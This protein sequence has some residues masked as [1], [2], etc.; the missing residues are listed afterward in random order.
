MIKLRGIEIELE[1]FDELIYKYIDIVFEFDS[2]LAHTNLTEEGLKRFDDT[3]EGVL[4]SI[5]MCNAN[6]P[7]DRK[8]DRFSLDCEHWNNIFYDRFIGFDYI[9]INKAVSGYVI[10]QVEEILS[11]NTNYSIFN[12]IKE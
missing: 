2:L 3:P 9:D 1:E 8:Y 5:L 6:N 7:D 11:S 4:E 10:N 12:L